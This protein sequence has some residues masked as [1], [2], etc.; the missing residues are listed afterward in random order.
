MSRVCALVLLVGA[1]AGAHAPERIAVAHETPAPQSAAPLDES[2]LRSDETRI[3]Q[4]RDAL[5]RDALTVELLRKLT[6]S[7]D[8]RDDRAI[9]FGARRVELALYGGYTTIW[10]RLLATAPDEHGASRIA[11][12]EFEQ[13]GPPE[14]WPGFAARLRA[15]WTSGVAPVAIVERAPAF[16]F[17]RE[18]AQLVRELHA[19]AERELGAAPAAEV[20]AAL[21]GAFRTLTSPFEA[22]VLGRSCFYDGGPPPGAEATQALVDA[23]RFDLLRVVLR[24]VNPEG[25]AWAAHALLERARAGVALDAADARAIASLRALPLELACCTGCEVSHEGFD[26]AL[27]HAAK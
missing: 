11:A 24:G 18:D 23:R 5:G 26:A 4:L 12:L 2:W 21:A 1:C 27:A 7:S 10:V 22:L 14:T 17:E 25:R 8:V 15:A 19:K 3:R 13:R 9:G 16:V 20:P 6:G